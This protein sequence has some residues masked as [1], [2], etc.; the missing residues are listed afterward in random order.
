MFYFI[1]CPRP[2][3]LFYIIIDNGFRSPRDLQD[4]QL[5]ELESKLKLNMGERERLKPFLAYVQKK[6]A[7]SSSHSGIGS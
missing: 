1:H 2:K 3:L 6:K 4:V 7:E 5:G